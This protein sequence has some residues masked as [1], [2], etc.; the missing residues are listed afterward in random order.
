M[1]RNDKPKEAK[2]HNALEERL[3][4]LFAQAAADGGPSV[5]D[6]TQRAIIQNMRQVYANTLIQA[7]IEMRVAKRLKDTAME[8]QIR[9]N[10]RRCLEAI[11][12]L[13]LALE[14]LDGVNDDV[15]EMLAKVGVAD[16]A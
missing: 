14:E 12:E 1:S 9:K 5:A 16:A 8:E 7:Q 2:E 4:A 10:A 11:S 13:D 15:D 3:D 6:A